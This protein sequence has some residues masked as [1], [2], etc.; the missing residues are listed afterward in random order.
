MRQETIA[1]ERRGTRGHGALEPILAR[2]RASKANE[3]IPAKA[4]AGR[5][6]DVGCGSYPIFL[7][8]TRFA[9]RFG[10][11]QGVEAGSVQGVEVRQHDLSHEP[12]LPFSDGFFNVVTMLAV[13][14]HLERPVLE[15]AFAEIHRVLAAGGSLVMT[16]PAPWTDLILK[17]MAGVGLLSVEEIGDHEELRSQRQLAGMLAAA[18]FAPARIKSGTFELGANLWLRAEKGP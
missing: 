6:L 2:L 8:N 3:L 4:R 12:R 5:I 13:L 17:A 7:L 9:E 14:E 16:T 18:G 1:V 15:R 11:D 10:I